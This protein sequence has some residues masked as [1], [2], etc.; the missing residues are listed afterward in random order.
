[1]AWTDRYLAL[2][3]VEP[4]TPN[5]ETLTRLCR[6]HVKT[7]TFE[8]VTALLRR[9]AAPGGGPVA[10]LDYDATLTAWEAGRSGGV[11]FEA[12]AMC[13]RL[14][15]AL[16]YQAHTVLGT[17]AFPGSHQAVRVTLPEGD[18][19]VDVACGSPILRP[20]PLSG[21]TQLSHVGL[22]YR[23]L[24]GH[25]PGTWL[26]QRLIDGGWETFC[27][28]VLAQPSAGQLETAYQRHQRPGETW[29]T[30]TLTLIRCTDDAVIHLRNDQVMRY[31]TAGKTTE[32]VADAAAI[33]CLAA[34]TFRLPGADVGSALQVRDAC[35]AR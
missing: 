13:S 33:A 26:Q 11:C 17:I 27:T 30:S 3:G 28:Y 6:A 5:L 10:P 29:V 4:H 9:G 32:T 15:V 14:L 25:E 19:L 8:N 24:A 18:Y 22:T 1:M 16:G 21:E 35:L 20:I 34:D 7:V 31:T 2:L 12:A 23:F